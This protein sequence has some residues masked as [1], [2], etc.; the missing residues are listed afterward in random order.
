MC[1]LVCADVVSVNYC[2]L[3]RVLMLFYYNEG[4]FRV[5]EP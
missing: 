4:I 2:S 1:E 3:N 5:L